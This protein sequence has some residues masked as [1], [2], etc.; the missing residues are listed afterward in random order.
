[1]TAMWKIDIKGEVHFITCKEGFVQ[2]VEHHMGRDAA[3]WLNAF[4]REG[5]DFQQSENIKEIIERLRNDVLDELDTAME[6]IE[7]DTDTARMENLSKMW[8]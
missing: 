4:I 1:M 8:A 3:D 7:K 2:L 6:A 5:M